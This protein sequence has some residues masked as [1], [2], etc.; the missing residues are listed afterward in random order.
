[1]PCCHVRV[2]TRMSGSNSCL[3]DMDLSKSS[4]KHEITERNTPQLRSN[5]VRSAKAECF[6][7]MLDEETANHSSF[8][9]L[10]TKLPDKSTRRKICC[11]H[12]PH[13]ILVCS[14]HTIATFTIGDAGRLPGNSRST[15]AAGRPQKLKCTHRTPSSSS[16][17]PQLSVRVVSIRGT[18]H[19]PC[20]FVG[21]SETASVAAALTRGSFVLTVLRT[22]KT[23][24]VQ[25]LLEVNCKADSQELG[26]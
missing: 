21:S 8:E 9:S 14:N 26:R 12:A 20:L 15:F 22:A 16:I 6:R 5:T 13:E 17:P 11:A 2:I 4:C 24:A 19:L 10:R 7:G 23:P 3:T 1:M 25:L 18:L